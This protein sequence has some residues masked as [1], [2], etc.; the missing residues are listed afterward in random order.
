MM[1]AARAA[2]VIA[3]AALLS[4]CAASDA[5]DDVPQQQP[6]RVSWA[7][8]QHSPD[9]NAVFQGYAI[10]ND[11]SYDAKGKINSGLALTGNTLL[12][13]TFSHK[14]VALDVRT[15]RELWHAKLPNV[16]MSTPIVAGNTVY[17]G[18]GSNGVLKRNLVQRVQFFQKDVWGTPAG[19]EV[20]AFDLDTG[21]PRW[22]HR[23]VGEN[24]PSAV[25]DSGRLI[26]ANGDWHAYALSAGTGRQ[27]WSTDLGGVSTMASAV[28]AGKAVVVAVCKRG[29]RESSA[30]ALD[31]STGK[32]LWRSPYGH[33]DAAPAYA[34]GKV[35][36]SSL[37]P[38]A[39]GLSGKTVVA[40]LDAKSGQPLWVY[41]GPEGLWSIVGSSEAAIAGAYAGGTY[42][43]P[44]PFT[45]D[46]LAF[47]ANTG[48]VKWNF[49]TTGPVKMSPV[50]SNG[51]VYVGDTA[52]L[53]YTIDARTGKL[54]ELR[55]FSKPF[56]TSPPI[57]AGNKVLVVNGMSVDAIPLSGRPQIGERVGWA[58]T[59]SHSAMDADQ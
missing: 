5:K 30:I 54:L 51:R 47:D 59:G 41:R 42:Y 19:D 26:F 11:W 1:H 40:A 32:I 46:L 23:T 45:D 55:E 9:R 8:Y 31:S 3:A 12:F 53:F 13:T 57:V 48:K 28:L 7:M 21:K 29:M 4:G 27:L 43:Q 24:M 52:G 22:Q 34:D 25:Y 35:F 14:L 15:G 17:V 49:N 50:I 37:L 16:T 39:T 44:A 18:T 56:T 2:I 58:V 36:V 6:Q 38:G 20:A 10:P 33:C